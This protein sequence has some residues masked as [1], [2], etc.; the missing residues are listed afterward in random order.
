MSVPISLGLAGITRLGSCP[1][2]NP[3][4][5]GDCGRFP[6]DEYCGEGVDAGGVAWCEFYLVARGDSCDE[7]CA[8]SGS[9]CL[10][11][12]DDDSGGCEPDNR[13]D[14]DDGERDLICRCAR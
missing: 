5:S 11:A 9:Y 12:F 1:N 3:D 7:V 6:A 13:M 10:T 14:C 4:P 8:R 2:P